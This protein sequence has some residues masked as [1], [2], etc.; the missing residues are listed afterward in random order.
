[1]QVAASLAQHENIL[2]V[3]IPLWASRPEHMCWTK[4]ITKQVLNLLVTRI[5]RHLSSFHTY[6]C[7]NVNPQQMTD[8]LDRSHPVRCSGHIYATNMARVGP[9]CSERRML[10]TQISIF[11]HGESLIK[12]QAKLKWGISSAGW[13]KSEDEDEMKKKE[14]RNARK[15]HGRSITKRT[16][17]QWGKTKQA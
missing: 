10:T 2:F 17:T 3:F 12:T 13:T 11:S 9:R 15:Q 1:M 14:A 4:N 5:N 6:F 16:W 8:R 7:P